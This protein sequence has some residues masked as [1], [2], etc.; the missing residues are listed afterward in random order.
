MTSGKSLRSSGTESRV[1]ANDLLL[2]HDVLDPW[3]HNGE[4]GRTSR[5]PNPS[6]KRRW[7]IIPSLR[8]LLAGSALERRR[9]ETVPGTLTCSLPFILLT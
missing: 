4:S 7:R 5:L 2:C 9:P 1:L 6:R 8:T 3:D